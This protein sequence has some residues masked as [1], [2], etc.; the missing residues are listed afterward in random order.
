MILSG[1]DV[2]QYLKFGNLKFTPE[3]MDSQFQ[4]NGIDLILSDCEKQINNFY[5]GVTREFIE[6]P[7]DLMAFVQIRSSYAR[8]GFI[9][10]PTVVDAG[11]KGT[12]TIELIRCGMTEIKEI[13]G[14]R[15]IHLIFAK[16]ASPSEPYN[17]KYQG[18][19]DIT[20]AY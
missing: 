3:L 15:F 18:Q 11:F 9:L 19:K 12:L 13:I 8:K 14:K 2:I 16:L 20:K 7:N 4:Q 6:M 10:P 5:L 17:G 1:N